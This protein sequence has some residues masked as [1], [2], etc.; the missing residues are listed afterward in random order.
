VSSLH[1]HQFLENIGQEHV[2]DAQLIGWTDKLIRSTVQ[3]VP[4]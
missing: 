1:F 4:L 2:C 3:T